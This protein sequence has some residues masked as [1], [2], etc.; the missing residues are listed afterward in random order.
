MDED[1]FWSIVESGTRSG[2]EDCSDRVRQVED[3]LVLLSAE[4]ILA[5]RDILDSK[6][7]ESY[8]AELWGAAYLINQGCSNDG[9]G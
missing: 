4:E 7:A 2:G 1:Q 3:A 8:R 6:L 9:F 5:F